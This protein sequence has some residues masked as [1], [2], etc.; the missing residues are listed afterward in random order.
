MKYFKKVFSHPSTHFNLVIVGS[1][2]IIQFLHTRAH[3]TMEYD[4]DAHVRRTL[5]KN[6]ELIKRICYSLD[7]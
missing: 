1:L 2:I 4:A 5:S 3:Y 6:P 7:D